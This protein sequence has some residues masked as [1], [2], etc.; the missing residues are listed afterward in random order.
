MER[1]GAGGAAGAAGAAQL[2]LENAN[3]RS[4]SD[5]LMLTSITS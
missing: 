1:S 3:K 2:P 4:E 5:V